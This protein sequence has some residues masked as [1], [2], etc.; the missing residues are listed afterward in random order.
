MKWTCF[1]C[2]R[3]LYHVLTQPC[4]DL[5]SLGAIIQC[6]Q[7]EIELQSV[8]HLGALEQN[9]VPIRPPSSLPP[10]GTPHRAPR[11]HVTV[12]QSTFSP[13]RLLDQ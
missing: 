4:S 5:W 7:L 9:M 2:T 6:R 8:V 13:C 12:P 1:A 11:D 10:G 3:F